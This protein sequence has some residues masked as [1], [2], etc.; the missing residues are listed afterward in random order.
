MPNHKK[1]EWIL[2]IGVAGEF[3]GHGVLA[4]SGKQDWINWVVQ[5]SGVEVTTAA[6]L[7]TLIGALD[8]VVAAAVFFKPLNQVLLWATFWGFFTAL[9]RPM[10]GMPIW[11]F[12]ERFANWAAPLALYYFYKAHKNKE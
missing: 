6:T 11:D 8:V 9:V 4:I 12:V 5:L 1:L 3:L 10:V 2:R 7:V